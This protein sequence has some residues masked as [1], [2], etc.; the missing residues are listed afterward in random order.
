MRETAVGLAELEKGFMK[1]TYIHHS[2][3]LVET[4]TKYLL[5]DYYEGKIPE[6]EKDKPLF[7][8]AS[9]RHGDH[10][11]PVIFELAKNHPEV[12]YILSSDIWRV[13]IPEDLQE[14]TV[15]MKSHTELEICE[16]LMVKTLKSTDEG[17]AFFVTCDGYRIYHAGDLNN[18]YWEGE[19][20]TWNEKMERVYRAEIGR[21]SDETADAAFIPLDPR[22]G[23]AFYLGIHQFMQYSDA[24]HI[25]P[26]HCWGDFSVIER[27]K[28]M[29]CS[30]SYRDRIADIREDGQAFEI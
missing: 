17:V 4:G 13:R 11:S 1:I 3:F 20:D 8:F 14:Q 24:K 16:G 19:P 23:E 18:W 10:F 27:I 28:E 6:L 22:Q 26:M 2:S 21:I 25:F 9:H 29:P 30:E 5:F 7:V 12:T 15:S